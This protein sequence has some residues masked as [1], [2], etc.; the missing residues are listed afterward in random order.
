M[1]G[2]ASRGIAAAA[3]DRA[4]AR[5]GSRLPAPGRAGG[6]PV[7]T[8][9]DSVIDFIGG[10]RATR[11]IGI[12]L[13]EHDMRVVMK[14][15]ERVQVLDNGKTLAEGSASEIRTNQRVLEAYL[16]TGRVGRAQGR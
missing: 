11:G 7:S 1:G 14:L 6:G 13:V 9:T 12:V 10:I 16:G 4:G 2:H 15:C 5:G 3:R 8:E